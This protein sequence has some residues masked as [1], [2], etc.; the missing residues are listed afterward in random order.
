M[1][2]LLGLGIAIAVAAAVALGDEWRLAI[3]APRRPMRVEVVI[4]CSLA[5]GFGVVIA[6]AGVAS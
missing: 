4:G 5:I 1:L 6:Y 2:A 3:R